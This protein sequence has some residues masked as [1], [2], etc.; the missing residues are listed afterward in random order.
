[1][2]FPSRHND[3]PD[4]NRADPSLAQKSDERVR[5]PGPQ[6]SFLAC[7][8][9]IE[10]SAI[11]GDDILEQVQ[12]RANLLQIVDFSSRHQHEPAARSEQPL[13]GAFRLGQ[14]PPITRQGAVVIGAES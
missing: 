7:R 12:S 11:L 9:L 6:W 4:R 8:G 3:A 5:W 14:D 13:Q 10:K 1:M 2:R